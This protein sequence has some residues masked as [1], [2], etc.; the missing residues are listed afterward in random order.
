MTTQEVADKLVALCREGKNMEAVNTLYSDDIVSIEPDGAPV[1]EVRGK[2]GVLG[3]TQQFFEMIEEMHG[4]HTSDP[5][6]AGNHFSCSMSMDITMKG[7]G[8]VNMDEI[9]VYEVKDGKIVRE[10]FFFTAMG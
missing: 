1:K 7:V 8:R 9:C 2:E 3:K 10:E 4:G 6:V 5:V